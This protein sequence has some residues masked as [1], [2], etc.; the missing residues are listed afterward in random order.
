MRCYKVEKKWQELDILKEW[1]KNGIPQFENK[2]TSVSAKYHISIDSTKMRKFLSDNI[3]RNIFDDYL[4]LEIGADGTYLNQPQ[5]EFIQISDIVAAKKTFTYADTTL[6]VPVSSKIKISENLEGGI[7]YRIELVYNKKE[8]R[9][10]FKKGTFRDDYY[11]EKIKKS[12]PYYE[13]ISV[14][15]E[16]LLNYETIESDCECELEFSIVKS[17]VKVSQADYDTN[18]IQQEVTYNNEDFPYIRLVTLYKKRKGEY[19]FDK[20]SLDETKLRRIL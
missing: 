4:Q 10:V 19:F 13:Y 14:A 18:V 7:D 17:I 8:N 12:T 3:K 2:E 1:G 5:Y 16:K 9:W 20:I 15:I 11:W 6:N